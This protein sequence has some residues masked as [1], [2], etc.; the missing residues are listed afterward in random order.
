M[1]VRALDMLAPISMRSLIA[2]L[3]S[4]HFDDG[5]GVPPVV[6]PGVTKPQITVR[7]E[8]A[9]A[10]SVF[11]VEGT[12]FVSGSTVTVRIVDDAFTQQNRQQ[13]A[14]A[15]GN[16]SMRISLPCLSGL[17]LHFSATDSR[18]DG[19]DLTGVLFSNTFD[20]SCP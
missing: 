3:D 14:D 6:T 20:I 13:S 19:S 1:M 2:L 11:V 8:S 7:S 17:G 10:G 15:N 9:G 5:T 4:L 12:G 16:L 18:P